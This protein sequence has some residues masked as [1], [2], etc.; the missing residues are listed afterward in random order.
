MF[1]A[2]FAAFAVIIFAGPAA[3]AELEPGVWRG[4]LTA[5]N[6]RARDSKIETKAALHL[7]PDGNQLYLE[8]I[9]KALPVVAIDAAK[10]GSFEVTASG[11]AL[12]VSL[13]GLRLSRG[14]LEG[15]VIYAP[16]VGAPLTG[17]VSLDRM[18]PLSPPSLR[19]NCGAAP[20]TLKN[21]CGVWSGIS[22]RGQPKLLVIETITR[23]KQKIAWELKAKQSW[24]GDSDLA[25]AGMSF[26]Y[27]EYVTDEQVPLAILPLRTTGKL[28]YRF[29][30]DDA[31]HMTGGHI[32]DP[33]D[34]TTYTRVKK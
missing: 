21:L 18:K 6:S 23:N 2:F 12:Q 22:L 32:A 7:G 15:G 26:P 34:R 4:T 28:S 9:N 24:G 3:T 14:D 11:E 10:D 20:E 27:T 17:Q 8:N 25:S 1:R 31:D 30:I 5:E 29:E 33:A 16:D 19:A 13:R